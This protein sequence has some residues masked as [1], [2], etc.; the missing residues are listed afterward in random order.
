MR[1]TLNEV[2]AP[3]ELK[4]T[5]MEVIRATLPQF[6]FPAEEEEGASA[7]GGAGAGAGTSAA[8]APMCPL[9]ARSADGGGVNGCSGAAGGGGGSAAAM[10]GRGHGRRR[11]WR[12]ASGPGA[13]A[14]PVGCLPGQGP[15]MST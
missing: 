3:L 9:H 2:G 5:A 15:V 6:P 12:S 13:R 8:S 1:E 7:Q 4:A 11:L 14:A 10:G